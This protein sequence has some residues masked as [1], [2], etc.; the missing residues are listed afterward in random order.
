MIK[1]NFAKE[2]PK[3]KDI[4]LI[5]IKEGGRKDAYITPE[6]QKK[7]VVGIGKKKEFSRRKLIILPRRIISLAKARR[8]KK[9]A[10]NFDELK[11]LLKEKEGELAEILITNLEMGNFEFVKYKTKPQEGWRFIEEVTLYG[12]M[13]AST[14]RGAEKGQ[15]IGDEI[16][17]CRELVNT[18]GGEMTPKLLASTAEKRAEGTKVKVEVLGKS[19][20]RKLKMGGILGVAEGSKE[21][22]K[23]IVMRYK[24]SAGQP[25]VLVGKGVTFDTG[26]LNIKPDLSMNEMHMDMSGGAAALHT[27]I[28]AAKLKLKKH[29]VVLIPA[30]ENMPSGSSYRP[31]DILRTMS[32]KTIEVGHT[33]AEGRVIL[34]DAITYAKEFKPKLVI[35]VA[36]LTGSAMAALGKRA[37]AILGKDE[38][39]VSQLIEAGESVGDYAWPLPLWDEYEED[40]KGT[41]G[42]VTN[43]GKTRYGGAITAAMFLYQFAKELDCP[44]AHIDMAPRMTSI[45]G[46]YLA[47]GAAGAPIGLLMRFL[48]NRK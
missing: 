28:L 30:V 40:I 29:I 10:I 2:A 45:H 38:K 5:E 37:S 46:E 12:K 26:G 43:S 8:I 32:G 19:D 22:P 47:K 11:K 15:I 20:I 23:L 16:N 21:E 6:A 31:G 24:G 9:I 39:M 27:I 7:I 42:D 34:A 17:A 18:P 1:L 3:N 4:A 48:Q 13:G 44:W 14:K 25:M 33:D 35:D 36:T 41:F